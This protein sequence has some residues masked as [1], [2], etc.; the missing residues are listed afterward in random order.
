MAGV[1]PITLEVVR[2]RLDGIVREMQVAV[3][4]TGYSTI[5]RES[6]DFSC[7][8]MDRAGGV[9]GQYSG[10]PPHLGAYP[11]CIQGLL[12]FYRYEEMEEGDT[13]IVNHPYFSGCPHAM[14]M[15]I[16]TP[17][18]YDGELVAFCASIG[19]KSDI[20]GLSPG[21]RSASARDVFGE[22][23]HVLPVKFLSRRQPVKETER[24]IRGNSR[25]PDLV[26]G[27]LGA[28]AGAS[29]SVGVQRLREL[30]AKYGRELVLAAFQQ[31]GLGTERRLRQEIGRW[32]DGVYEAEALVDNPAEP[33]RPIRVHLAA[34]KEG[35]R[36]VLDFSGSGDQS[37]GPINVRPPF[38]KGSSYHVLIAMADRSLPNNHGLARAVEFRFRKGSIVDP[39]F[40][41]PVGFYSKTLPVVEGVLQSALSRAAGRPALA[42]SG[43]QSSLI[44]GNVGE[45]RRPYVQYE[46]L[47]AGGPAFDG[48][49][50]W[51]G[52]GHS[53]SGGSK[54]TS[55]EIVE[56]EFDVQLREFRVL[57]DSGGA[58]K[59][60]GGSGYARE[61]L[62]RGES[63][64]TGG[65]A[66][67]VAAGSLG[68]LGGAA[69]WVVV[70]P[71]TPREQ[72]FEAMV[73][74]LPLHPGD[75]LRIETA[76]G[77]GVGPP[78]ERDGERVLE[79]LQDGYISP[80]AAREVYGLSE[81]QLRQATGEA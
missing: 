59:Y 57:S 43:I 25:T 81:E 39:A 69:P 76:G 16:M 21:S 2:A 70:N 63:R 10:V 68:G 12:Q 28:Q 24:F 20:G 9:V 41:A 77:G 22:G 14:D 66:K 5:I 38:V 8:I 56:S 32:R 74:N 44:L 4:R 13:F 31:I 26:L 40:P 54:F 42:Y 53:F 79:D 61:Y 58:G 80:Q 64:F 15:G 45:A 55:V 36:L 18:F 17:V 46:L 27:D 65:A 33:E 50:G 60:R 30:M 29:W 75:V 11:E 49:D 52:T 37:A 1:D 34:I 71:G 48:G 3:L 47:M 7:A 19:H 35:E 72:R 62:A 78:G 51:A 6:H 73:S 67:H 23:L